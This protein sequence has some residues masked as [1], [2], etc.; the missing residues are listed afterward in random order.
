MDG[1]NSILVKRTEAPDRRSEEA[2]AASESR[3][4]AWE[5]RQA[6]ALAAIRDRCGY[7]AEAFVNECDS[8]KQAF[9]EQRSNYQP[10][11]SGQ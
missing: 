9:E 6:H 5:G 7:N 11:G 8:I 3:S 1:H 2:D 10:S 4:E